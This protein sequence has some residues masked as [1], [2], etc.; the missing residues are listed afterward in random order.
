VKTN[1]SK[2]TPGLLFPIANSPSCFLLWSLPRCGALLLLLLCPLRAGADVSLPAIFSAHMV[3]QKAGKVPVWGKASPGEHVAVDL[4]GTRAEAETDAQGKWKVSLNLLASAPGPYQLIV[5]GKNQLVVDDVLVGEVWLCGGQSNMEVTVF[6]TTNAHAEIAASANPQLR[7]FH[8]PKTSALQPR[9]DC[10]GQWVLA[11][12]ATTGGFTAVGYFFGKAIQ[13]A[14]QVPVGLI[15]DSF[16]GSA[17]ESWLSP[18]AIDQMPEIKATAAPLIADA[19]AYPQRLNEFHAKIAAW[20]EENHRQ[21]RPNA[22]PASFAAPD[23][24]TGD[25][26]T[27]TVPGTFS[28]PDFPENGAL[29]IRR[30]VEVPVKL[31]G[32]SL[33]LHLG[34]IHDFDQVY[35]DGAKVG[36]TTAAKSTSENDEERSSRDRRYDVPAALVKAGPATLAIRIFHPAG[37]AA[38]TANNLNAGFGDIHLAGEWLAKSE[39]ALGSPLAAPALADYPQAPPAPAIDRAVAGLLY[40]GMIHPVL[41]YGI[42]GIIWYQGEANTGRAAQYRSTFA[43]L[44][45]DWRKQWQEGT[46]PFY[47]CQLANYQAKDALPKESATAELRESQAAALSLPNTGQA[48]LIDLGEQDDVHFKDK[49]DVGDRLSYIALANTYGHPMPFSGPVYTSMQVAGREI[50]LHFKFAD[51]GLKAKPLPATYQPLSTLPATLPLVRNSP[52]SELQGFAICGADR[53]WV[54]A[55]ARIDG[56]DVVVWSDSVEK[57]VAVRYG[58]DNNPTVNL[59]NGAGLPA[60]PF[61]TDDFP[62]STRDRKY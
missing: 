44:I 41:P 49:K 56:D 45:D 23:I 18:D 21:D 60:S 32:H 37:P 27:V 9:D 43:L 14:L 42:R 33:P 24:A 1:P 51:G 61:R 25:W 20:L 40:N 54:W 46:I 6:S 62:L 48:V 4:S 10:Q 58:W 38:L 3:L 5:R 59:Y 19:A 17:I 55:D 30:S 39:Y 13:K 57:P 16:G 29:W 34:T 53:H 26:Q 28:G 22:D 35:W 11:G 12:P 50:R 31:A 36:G 7:V 2:T 52:H 15:S 8:V 47:F